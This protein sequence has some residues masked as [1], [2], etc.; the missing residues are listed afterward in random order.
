MQLLRQFVLAV[1]NN[2][3][4]YVRTSYGRVG[5]RVSPFQLAAWI[6]SEST[7][8]RY[9]GHHNRRRLSCC[10]PLVDFHPGAVEVFLP[11]HLSAMFVVNLITAVLLFGQFF[12]RAHAQHPTRNCECTHFPGAAHEPLIL[13]FPDVFVLGSG[14]IGKLQTGLCST[15]FGTAVLPLSCSPMLGCRI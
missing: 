9:R 4:L 2:E 10:G 11:I 14:V 6:D 3:C 13:S 1:A 8:T 15:L 7:S 5:A 12:D